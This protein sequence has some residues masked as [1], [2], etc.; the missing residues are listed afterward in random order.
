V[1]A[2]DSKAVTPVTIEGVSTNRIQTV[3]K[4]AADEALFGLGRRF[5]CHLG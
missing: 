4:S 5:V 3:F 2:E 1:L